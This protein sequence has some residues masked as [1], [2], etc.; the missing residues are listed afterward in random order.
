VN[1]NKSSKRLIILI[2]TI[3][4]FILTFA[5]NKI[6][7]PTNN[8]LNCNNLKN[9][10]I[11]MNSET[12]RFEVD[13]LLNDLKPNITETDKIGQNENINILINRLN[14]NCKN[15]TSE[16]ICYACIKTY[17]PQSEILVTTDSSGIKIKRIIDISTPSDSNLYLQGIHE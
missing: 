17:P 2:Y 14:N 7:E 5:C 16:L 1:T 6:V 13:K 10:I 15:I 9:G 8:N 12:V 11:N 3:F 4:L